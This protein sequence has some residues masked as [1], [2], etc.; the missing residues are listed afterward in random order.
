MSLGYKIDRWSATGGVEYDGGQ[1]LVGAAV[2]L[3]RGDT[4]MK[5]GTGGIE[6]EGLQFGAYANWSNGNA[7]IEA[8]GGI[9]RIDLD[10]SRDA[11]IDQIRATPDADTITAGAQIG[12]LFDVGRLKVGPVAGLSYAKAEVDGY[13]ET[14]DPVLTLNVGDQEVDQLV[15][16]LGVELNGS[17]DVGGARVSP[18]LTGSVQH[19]LNDEPRTI[20]YA[21]TAAPEIVNRWTL[22]G[23]AETY[24]RVSLGANFQIT[25]GLTLQVAGATTFGQ[26][27][28]D[29]SHATVAARVGF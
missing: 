9:G 20:L 2:S 26:N 19:E 17:F 4:A 14:G 23:D 5:T 27:R 12:Y 22:R 28:G 24:G 18:F 21:G 25:D 3:T 11:V 29:D 15:G 8:H 7:F 13:T 16:S 10:I 6:S 1:W